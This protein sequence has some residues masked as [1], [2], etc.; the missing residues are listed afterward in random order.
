MRRRTVSDYLAMLR[1]L[2]PRGAAWRGEAGTVLAAM[3]EAS[4]EELVRLD[5]AARLLMDESNPRTAVDA[6][7][8]WERTL[9][10]PDECGGTADTLT[11]RRAQVLLKLV[12]P[13]GQDMPFF[14]A[15]AASMGY[16]ATVEEFR[17]FAADESGAEDY[18]NDAPGGAVVDRSASPATFQPSQYHGWLFVFRLNVAEA[19]PARWFQADSSGAEDRLATWGN[20]EFECA[21]N[22]AKP[23]HTIALF[24]YGAQGE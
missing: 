3:L 6:L 4:A 13:V 2:M 18:L 9:G 1:G 15:L 22:R 16:P 5:G 17:P 11:E 24:G 20:S 8:D 23:A 19:Y 12:R 21:I 10:L 14:E 7:A